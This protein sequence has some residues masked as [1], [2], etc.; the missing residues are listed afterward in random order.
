[1]THLETDVLI[2]GGGPAGLAAALYAAR[3]RRRTIIL[4]KFVPGGQ[5]NLTERIENYP[6]ITR[7]SGPDLITQMVHQATSFGAE[8][9]IN[10]QV[11]SLKRRDDDRLEVLTDELTCTAPVVI[12][13][14][15]SD[16]RRLGVPGET[17]FRQAGAGVSYCGTCDAP[18]FRD[19]HVVAIGGGNV[20]VEDSIHL[21]RFCKKVTL[22][23]RRQQ[24]RATEVLVDELMEIVKTGQI[25]LLLD[26]VVT[27]IE[28]RDHV[29]AVCL[30]NTKTSNE[31]SL[32]C[33][34]VFVFVG[35]VPNTRFLQGAVDINPHG[36]IRCDPA[37]LRTNIPGVFVAG[38]C[39]EGAPMQL[40]TAIAD[41]VTAALYLK[42]YLRNPQWWHER[43]VP[44]DAP[45]A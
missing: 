13:A 25:E 7:I 17:K 20:A 38:D 24:F 36:Y 31:S 1:M 27:A 11:S 4:D 14:P 30:K 43:R 42:E 34:G 12:L 33:D 26:H 9:R 8:I 45:Y 6:G 41:G 22:V 44:P 32:P 10:Q 18:F 15:G 5:I 21:A 29:E 16:Y 28:G 19:K 35:M 39:R 3:E 2:V 23:H 37:F 40:A